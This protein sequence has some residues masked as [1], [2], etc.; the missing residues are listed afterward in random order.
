MSATETNS[1][2]GWLN[3]AFRNNTKTRKWPCFQTESSPPLCTKTGADRRLW[4]CAA[5]IGI[6][7][8]E[9][10]WTSPLVHAHS[11][12]KKQQ[13]SRGH[14]REMLVYWQGVEMRLA[15][16]RKRKAIQFAI[17]GNCPTQGPLISTHGALDEVPATGNS[18]L[19]VLKN[20]YCC[21]FCGSD[22]RSAVP[23]HI[24]AWDNK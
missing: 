1:E 24:V 20:E 17:T 8:S 12:K 14:C 19:G 11:F 10:L 21:C 5:R 6:A 22:Y 9:A 23:N 18:L 13:Q 2:R 4:M 3:L 7:S 15:G 16:R